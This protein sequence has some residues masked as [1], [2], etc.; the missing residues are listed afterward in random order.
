MW[1]LHIHIVEV[2][3]SSAAEQENTAGKVS[4]LFL[5]KRVDIG[6]AG[7]ETIEN[8]STSIDRDLQNASANTSR[9][10]ESVCSEVRYGDDDP[11]TCQEHIDYLV[12][13]EHYTCEQAAVQVRKESAACS[14]CA[15]SCPLPGEGDVWALI[16]DYGI[17][18]ELEGTNMK[19]IQDG[20]VPQCMQGMVWMDQQ[21]TTWH[22]LPWGYHCVTGDG[23]IAVDEYTTGFKWWDWNSRCVAFG[24]DSWTFGKSN[25]YDEV[26]KYGDV[27]FCQTNQDTHKDP[28]E[29]GAHFELPGSHYALQKTSFG[30]DR[31]SYNIYHYPLLQ[32]IDWQGEKTNWFDDYWS[33]V[34]RLHCPLTELNCNLNQWASTNQVARCLRSIV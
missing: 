2:V 5:Q 12:D 18:E 28:C 21:C 34:S 30:W 15:P 1:L 32:V 10:L 31:I 23:F 27:V 9:G 22:K 3:L 33:V 8:A 29:E 17:A 4:N 25:I 19:N 7:A 14:H 11:Y 24:R 13:K 20:A 6:G 16:G 26:C